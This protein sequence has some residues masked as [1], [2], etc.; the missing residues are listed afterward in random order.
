MENVSKR[1]AMY[2]ASRISYGENYLL[3]TLLLLTMTVVWIKIP[4]SWWSTVIIYGILVFIVAL[5][6]EVELKRITKGYVITNGE[7]IKAEGIVRKKKVII[8]YQDVSGAEVKKGIVGTILKFGTVIVKS[9]KNEIRMEDV[10]DPEVVFKI[11]Q[12]KMDLTKNKKSD[13]VKVKLLKNDG[14]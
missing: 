2:R 4:H 8:P 10:K 5:L 14:T 3:V 13:D 11:I 7:L 6:V 1:E 9:S 12:N